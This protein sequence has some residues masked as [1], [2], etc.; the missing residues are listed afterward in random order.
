MTSAQKLDEGVQQLI[1]HVAH[2][3]SA[4]KTVIPLQAGEAQ[5][6][7]CKPT[8]I[9]VETPSSA[10]RV[11]LPDGPLPIDAYVYEGGQ[12]TGE[13]LVWVKDGLLI[14]IEQAWYTDV[15]PDSWPAAADVRV[16]PQQP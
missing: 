9:D 11:T 8:M 12:L 15:P 16:S 14:G 7:L 2:A 6:V 3:L 1:A 10:T 5:V 13:V 4:T